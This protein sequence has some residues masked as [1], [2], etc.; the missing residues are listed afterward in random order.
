VLYATGTENSGFSLFVQQDRLVFD[1]NA[2]DHHTVI[3][4]S[5][6]VPAGASELTVKVRRHAGRLGSASIEID[7]VSVG[8]AE[9]P[10]L[11]RMISSVGPSVGYDHGSPVSLRYEAPFAFQGT[12]HEVVIQASPEKYADSDDAAYAAEL[13]RQ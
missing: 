9:L 13:G 1:Y 10:L 5:V 8:E 12:L 3:E 11:M 2:F 7:G 4:S 6:P